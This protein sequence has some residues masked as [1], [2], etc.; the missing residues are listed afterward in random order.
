VKR[1]R[2]LKRGGR[3]VLWLDSVIN[4]ARMICQDSRS[5]AEGITG[6]SRSKRGGWF[7]LSALS[8]CLLRI[9]GS[10]I[11]SAASISDN[12]HGRSIVTSV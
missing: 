3:W 5:V 9:R 8:V 2:N 4:K 6:G 7:I 10:A 12:K 1:S 11:G